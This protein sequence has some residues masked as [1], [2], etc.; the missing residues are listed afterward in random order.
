MTSM[1]TTTRTTLTGPRA[2]KPL[3]SPRCS[4]EPLGFL[5]AVTLRRGVDPDDSDTSPG[6]SAQNPSSRFDL[7]CRSVSIV[8]TPGFPAVEGF[9]SPGYGGEGSILTILT[10]PP[11]IQRKTP[12]RDLTWGVKVSPSSGR[13]GGPGRV[14]RPGRTGWALRTL[15][16]RLAA[17]PEHLRR[18]GLRRARRRVPSSQRGG[19]S[20][21]QVPC[22]GPRVRRRRPCRR[23]C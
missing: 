19:R 1:G 20:A 7:G 8:R 21:L 13:R 10:P 12:G 14:G 15:G 17:L 4:V 9:S 6:D 22:R 2:A 23:P 16:G 3:F 11:A 18:R 5:A